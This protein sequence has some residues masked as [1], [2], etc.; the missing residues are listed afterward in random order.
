VRAPAGASL[1]VVARSDRAGTH[2]Q[3]V[4]LA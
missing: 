2:R 3:A 1:T 4:R